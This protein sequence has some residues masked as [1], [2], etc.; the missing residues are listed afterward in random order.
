[1]KAFWAWGLVDHGGRTRRLGRV[2][3]LM[4]QVI[5]VDG[6]MYYVSGFHT[7]RYQFDIIGIDFH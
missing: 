1:V 3:T 2:E 6:D 4:A 7:A 5:W